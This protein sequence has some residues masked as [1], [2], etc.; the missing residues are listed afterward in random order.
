[1]SNLK[2]IVLRNTF[3]IYIFAYL[4][5]IFGYLIRIVLS[6]G[7]SIE[8]YGFFYAL[9][10]FFGLLSIF[11]DLGF[12]QTLNYYGTKFYEQKDFKKIK[13]LFY[14]TF[15]IQMFISLVLSTIIFFI[16][17]SLII[18]YFN[19]DP[20]KAIYLKFALIYFIFMNISS[21]IITL[22][23]INQNYF[24]DN[25]LNFVRTSIAL[26][27][28]CSIYFFSDNLKIAVLSWGFAYVVIFLLA[29]YLAYKEYPQIKSEKFGY[30]KELF[31]KIWAYSWPLALSSGAILLLDR[32]DIQIITYFRTLGEVALYSNAMSIANIIIFAIGPISTMIMSFSTKLIE[33]KQMMELNYFI[34]KI[35]ELIIFFGIP[36]IFVFIL[37]PKEIIFVLY[38]QNYVAAASSLQILSIG[39][40]FSL[41]AT[42]NISILSAMGK[43]KKR[44]KIMYIIAA[45]NLTLGLILIPKL[46]I[47][48]A[49]IATSISFFLMFLFSFYDS[50]GNRILNLPIKKMFLP[51][52]ILLNIIFIILIILLKKTI[53]LQVF[54]KTAIIS[55]IAFGIYF[56]LGYLLKIYTIDEIKELYLD[57]KTVMLKK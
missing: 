13:T 37:F 50:D 49:A 19:Y 17:N 6:K 21:P 52:I 40:L 38:G 12:T 14:Y 46:G 7:L 57:F 33:S 44:L 28:S 41:F 8:E 45:V 42:I 47:N 35:Y 15:F 4:T 5:A 43:V 54:F 32:I 26:F 29:I 51:K 11:C 23:H 56:F 25:L 9:L 39:M 36:F 1:M 10:G 16:A 48:G 24:K 3:W 20:A 55:S 31:K 53:N 30:D 34:G 18:N 2:E 22:F 27:L